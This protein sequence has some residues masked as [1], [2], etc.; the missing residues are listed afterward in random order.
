MKKKNKDMITRSLYKKFQNFTRIIFFDLE[1]T[2]FNIYHNSIIEI[3]AI[4]NL[5]N[6]FSTLIKSKK[7]LKSKIVQ[8]TGITDDLL[9]NAE[10]SKIALLNFRDYVE[11]IPCK[12]IYLL[13][14]NCNGFDKPFLEMEFKKYN[15]KFNREIHFI[16]TLRM[17]QLVLPFLDY[18]SMK[19]LSSYFNIINP[20]AHRAYEDAD[21]LRK[22]YEVLETLF[23]QKF[24]VSKI[25]NVEK[26][27][28]N[29]YQN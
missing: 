2:G 13:A 21:T 23:H 19:S 7:P 10:E 18:H 25:S 26:I 17:A 6:K 15:I 9:K 11:C 27:L 5:E 16:D 20:N 24:N 14:H 28:L 4:D 1:T 12:E 8:V 29:P 3:G 22:I